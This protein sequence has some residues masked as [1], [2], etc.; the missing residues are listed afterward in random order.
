MISYLVQ[1]TNQGLDAGHIS[2]QGDYTFLE[3]TPSFPSTGSFPRSQHHH[4]NHHNTATKTITTPHSFTT[5]SELML[6]S[7]NTGVGNWWTPSIDPFLY[8][9]IDQPLHWVAG[10][11]LWFIVQ[12]I[13]ICSMVGISWCFFIVARFLYQVWRVGCFPA[14]YWTGIVN[15]ERDLRQK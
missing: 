12:S 11:C 8:I 1:W 7:L 13:S 14:L 15:N 10:T 2:V 5:P 6:G 4:Q 3:T 9:S